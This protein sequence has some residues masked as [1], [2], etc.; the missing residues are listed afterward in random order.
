MIVSFMG[1]VLLTAVA[2]GLPAIWLIDQQR[3]HQAWAQVVQGSQAAQSLYTARQ[4]ELINLA[5]LLAQ[6][7]TLRELLSHDDMAALVAYLQTLQDGAGLDLVV[8]CDTGQRSVANAGEPVPETICAADPA[9]GYYL[10]PAA[11]DQVWLV[12]SQWL[13]NESQSQV[14]VI[15]GLRLNDRFARQMQAQTGLDH[16]LLAQ[17]QLIASSLPGDRANWQAELDTAFGKREAARVT[18]QGRSFYTQPFTLHSPD[19]V[20]QVALDVTE[21]MI[22]Q[23][24]LV[25]TLIGSIIA[26][27]VLGS[28]LSAYLARRIVRPLARLTG[29]ASHL[30]QGHL[31]IPIAVD[32]RVHEVALVAQALEQARIDLLQSLTELRQANAWTERLLDSIVEGIVTLDGQGRIT[33]FSSG[34]ERITGWPRKVV[35][36]R[37]CD[38]IF[39]RVETDAPF[40]QIL[41]AAGRRQK[42]EVELAGGRTATLAVTGAQLSP[43][44]SDDEAGVALVFRDVS[45]AEVLHRLVGHFLANVAHEFRTPL[46]AL[47]ASVELLLDQAPDLT[48]AELQELLISLNLGIL[49]LQTLVDNLLESASLEAGR[50]RVHMR[51]ANLN[52]IVAEPLRLMQPLLEKYG[53]RLVVELPV[54]C[55]VV[56]ADPRRTMQVLVNLLA[57][58][59]KYSPD[60]TEI[61]LRATVEEGWIR[62][63]VADQ[64]PGISPEYQADLF[65]RFVP[66]K[67]QVDHAQPGAGLGLSVVKAIVEAQGGRVGVEAR[68]GGGSIFWFTL[69]VE[70]TT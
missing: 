34:A 10:N 20:A 26:V 40:S 38:D 19:L 12:A 61:L 54:T 16:I 57:N 2:V 67:N 25:W 51:P 50:F 63:Q 68:I 8:V 17:G 30:S 44:G 69:P 45:E 52:Q 46:S 13:T 29:A 11:P 7:P 49:G 55:P 56:Q 39:H 66:A 4:A 70:G 28:I 6:R 35:I 23:R 58:A 60:Q 64:G 48:E 65:R 5:T 27:A 24:R 59:S 31:E 3:D 53:Q 9:T 22:T 32:A 15:V 36:N 18:W 21:L 14:E 41:P 1:L 47:G 62:I 37:R 43:P 42:I 33:F